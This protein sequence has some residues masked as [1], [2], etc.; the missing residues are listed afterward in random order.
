MY[1]RRRQ[2]IVCGVFDADGTEPRHCN[3]HVSSPHLHTQSTRLRNTAHCKNRYLEV[4][5]ARTQ[6]AVACDASMHAAVAMLRE[7]Q[8]RVSMG[9]VDDGTDVWEGGRLVGVEPHQRALHLLV[10]PLQV[11]RQT[12]ICGE[13]QL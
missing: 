6:H 3:T 13:K 4:V 9:W 2:T 10:P 11:R 7:L 8:R 5:H 1:K 12:P